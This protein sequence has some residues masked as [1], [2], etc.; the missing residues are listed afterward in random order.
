MSQ[1]ILERV[2]IGLQRALIGLE[3]VVG[4]KR[5]V[6]EVELR[7]GVELLDLCLVIGLY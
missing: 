5:V 2:V 3:V 7:S 1:T 4:L 6:I